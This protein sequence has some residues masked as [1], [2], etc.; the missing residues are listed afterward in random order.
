MGLKRLKAR[1]VRI[2]RQLAWLGAIAAGGLNALALWLWA[3]DGIMR[4]G[5]APAYAALIAGSSVVCGCIGYYFARQIA[6]YPTLLRGAWFGAAAGL[7]VGIIN[8][9]CVFAVIGTLI[10]AGIGLVAGLG[11]GLLLAKFAD[12]LGLGGIP[13]A[14]LTDGK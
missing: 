9:T 4:K 1:T 7:L 6:E 11:C 3:L 5:I 2:S 12:S 8:G 13:P 14:D 10:G